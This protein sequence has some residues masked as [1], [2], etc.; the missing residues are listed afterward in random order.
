MQ[1]WCYSLDEGA[2]KSAKQLLAL[3]DVINQTVGDALSD[4]LLV[5]TVLHANGWSVADWDAAYVDLPNRQMKVRQL[6]TGENYKTFSFEFR[7]CF[8]FTEMMYKKETGIVIVLRFPR[9]VPLWSFFFFKVPIIFLN[10]YCWNVQVCVA[11]RNV[12]QTAD[13]ERRCVEP[14]ELQREID[15]IVS[16]YPKGRSFVRWKKK[17]MI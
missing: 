14:P 17:M 6:C 2:L 1:L 13:A 8:F 3:I 7:V 10:F 9:S 15:A 5:E 12:I 11:D 16:E 4:L